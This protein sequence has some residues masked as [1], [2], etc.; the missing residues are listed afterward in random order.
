LKTILSTVKDDL[1]LETGV[2]V[3]IRDVAAGSKSQHASLQQ[4]LLQ[5]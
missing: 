4:P 3:V 1:I 5:L 2:F